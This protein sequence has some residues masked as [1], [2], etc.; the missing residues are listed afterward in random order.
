MRDSK[1]DPIVVN[2]IH[3]IRATNRFRIIS[4]TNNFGQSTAGIEDSELKFLGWEGGAASTS[5]QLVQLFDDYIDSSVVGL[6]KPDPAI[7]RLACAR[8]D[9][10]P[11]EVVMLD[12]L[13][14]NLR[15]ASQ[16]GMRTIQVRIGRSD[17][18][19]R[20]LG[21]ILGLELVDDGKKE[22]KL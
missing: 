7:Y 13:K 3:K 11:E 8:N 9:L 6:R 17:E 5:P 15:T 18:A 16:L 14:M 4:V 2:A 22:F 1:F 21:R 20:E 19:V 12:D 10:K